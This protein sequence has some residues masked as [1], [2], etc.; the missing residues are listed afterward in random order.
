MNI[1]ITPKSPPNQRPERSMNLNSGPA[2][3]TMTRPSSARSSTIAS[4][5]MESM[6]MKSLASRLMRSR[7]SSV[8]LCTLRRMRS[9]M[10]E[11]SFSRPLPLVGC[12]IGR[13]LVEDL[14]RDVVDDSL[15]RLA[16]V[17]RDVREDLLEVEQLVVD[18]LAEAPRQL[19]GVLRHDALP[20]EQRRNPD[21]LHR[22]EHRLHGDPV[23][24]PADEPADERYAE[25]ERIQILRRSHP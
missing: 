14:L 16:V 6:S 15:D 20:A 13:E 12:Q 21:E 10:Y 18:E 5:T 7:I 17:V 22:V 1:W 11:R 23:G 19:L 24:E 4:R 2:I 25:D 8:T 9:V 3:S